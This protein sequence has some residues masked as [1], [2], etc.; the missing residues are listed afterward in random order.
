MIPN[1]V[2]FVNGVSTR[3]GGSG[4]YAVRSWLKSLEDSGLDPYHYDIHPIVSEKKSIT[5]KTFWFIWFL[6]GSI[7]RIANIKP[8]ESF[9]KIGLVT[10]VEL[11]IRIIFG[12]YKFVVFSHYMVLLYGCL[13]PKKSRIF[14]AQD[15]LY[16]RYKSLGYPKAVC[17][18]VFKI[19]VT[20]YNKFNKVLFLSYHEKRLFAKFAKTNIHLI[21][22]LDLPESTNQ[23]N[24]NNMA[25]GIAIVSDWRR[26]ENIHGLKTYFSKNQNCVPQFGASKV[27]NKFV[28]YGF[29]C[30]KAYSILKKISSDSVWEVEC[31]GQYNSVSEIVQS[32]FLIPIYQGAGIK[33]K[34]IEALMHGKY[35]IGTPGAF[36]GLPRD[37]ISG[38]VQVSH[39]VHD[40]Y[41]TNL[42]P[43]IYRRD[44]FREKYNRLFERI[45]AAISLATIV[46]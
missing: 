15:L 21:S 28:L 3:F 19:E 38:L 1:K 37:L 14:I 39:S 41:F 31:R 32:V 29:D 24:A 46:F 2:L 17:K 23:K 11:F 10:F 6:P 9:Y 27:I 44:S 40:V 42:D 18:A 43:V 8:F 12:R 25:D 30:D 7:F 5:Q 33:L 22:C 35:V 45:G 4:A 34:T 13:V 36:T 26:S 20:A 16:R